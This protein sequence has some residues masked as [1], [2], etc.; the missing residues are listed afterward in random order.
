M[1]R[2]VEAAHR[3]QFLSL[4]RMG[5]GS[6]DHSPRYNGTKSRSMSFATDIIVDCHDLEE[7]FKNFLNGCREKAQFVIKNC[8]EVPL[9]SVQSEPNV[10]NDFVKA[11]WA[12]EFSISVLMECLPHFVPKQ[13]VSMILGKVFEIKFY[14]VIC[15]ALIRLNDYTEPERSANLYKVTDELRKKFLKK[16]WSELETSGELDV[17][18]IID[19]DFEKLIKNGNKAA[20]LLKGLGEFGLQNFS[21]PGK[22]EDEMQVFTDAMGILSYAN[23]LVRKLVCFSGVEEKRLQLACAK[24]ADMDIVR[25]NGINLDAVNPTQFHSNAIS[26]EGLFGCGD[27]DL[28]IFA[29]QNLKIQGI[30]CN[31]EEGSKVPSTSHETLFKTVAL[32]NR[33]NDS[34]PDPSGRRVYAFK[35]VS[36]KKPID[37]TGAPKKRNEMIMEVDDFSAEKRL[38]A[39]RILFQPFPGANLQEVFSAVKSCIDDFGKFSI[40]ADCEDE[41]DRK[42]SAYFKLMSLRAD[43]FTFGN[44]LGDQPDTSE[45]LQL[46]ESC[47]FFCR[48]VILGKSLSPISVSVTSGSVKIQRDER[49]ANI[50]GQLLTFL[51]ENV[52]QITNAMSGNEEVNRA[53]QVAAMDI[54]R[55]FHE[56]TFGLPADATSGVFR[57]I[58]EA[59]FYFLERIFTLNK[60]VFMESDEMCGSVLSTMILLNPMVADRSIEFHDAFTAAASIDFVNQFAIYFLGTDTENFGKISEFQRR[61]LSVAH[62]LIET[63]KSFPLPSTIDGLVQFQLQTKSQ[64]NRIKNINGELRNFCRA[65]NWRSRFLSVDASSK[66]FIDLVNGNTEDA[67][68]DSEE[69]SIATLNSKAFRRSLTEGQIRQFLYA[70]NFLVEKGRD[71]NAYNLHNY[72]IMPINGP[73]RGEKFKIVFRQIDGSRNMTPFLINKDGF[74][75]PSRIHKWDVFQNYLDANVHLMRNYKTNEVKAYDQQGTLVYRGKIEGND[76][77]QKLQFIELCSGATI[78]Y[79]TLDNFPFLNNNLYFPGSEST[80]KYVSNYICVFIKTFPGNRRIVELPS[81]FIDEKPLQ[82]EEILENEVN[83]S[84]KTIFVPVDN[85]QLRLYTR[86]EISGILNELKNNHSTA[87]FSIPIGPLL[88]LG[89]RECLP[90]DNLTFTLFIPFLST[91]QKG[92]PI[93]E[94]SILWRKW[95]FSFESM[96]GLMHIGSRIKAQMSHSCGGYYSGMRGGPPTYCHFSGFSMNWSPGKFGQRDEYQIRTIDPVDVSLQVFEMFVRSFYG[97]DYDNALQWMEMIPRISP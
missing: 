68:P 91:S 85:S 86:G 26:P 15:G 35:A 78:E 41:N 17:L 13:I 89:P 20:F 25:F 21:L 62:Y 50:R 75:F 51:A 8:I 36:A 65:S 72:L 39:K 60:K 28:V 34:P 37:V 88:F 31:Y 53:V 18:D 58:L 2:K 56:E 3:R 80:W 69:M 29:I 95:E 97:R 64:F 6:S 4:S 43:G 77:E 16:F 96:G 57:P 12:T 7:R 73:H 79:L 52:F 94:S 55:G 93:L 82:L 14:D 92:M 40:L 10:C 83:G 48:E 74:R 59:H 22:I 11:I 76:G 71:A 9:Q 30:K 5:S 70:T 61:A 87:N 24:E 19:D 84:Q 81:L 67:A 27:M 42:N 90:Q 44:L 45:A 47:R 1:H 66:L 49:K 32:V 23:Q 63:A 38:S 54:L 46:I 33:L